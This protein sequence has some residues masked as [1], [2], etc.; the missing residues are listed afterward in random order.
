VQNQD[1]PE[2]TNYALSDMQR[3]HRDF[4]LATW[5]DDG[6]DLTP[7]CYLRMSEFFPHALI[8][9]AGAV[10]PLRYDPIP[11]IAAVTA[12]TRDGVFTLG[13]FVASAPIDG[14]IVMH[15]GRIVYESYPRM[16]ADDHHI[17]WSVTKTLA[18][19]LV[20]KL[21]DD[22]IVDTEQP[23]DAY[24]PELRSSGWE[25]VSVLDILDMA[26]GINCLE[27]DDPVA[28]TS[29]TAPFFQ[30]EA[31]L[32]MLPATRRTPL[33]T[34]DYIAGLKRLQA[35]G[36]VFQYT[37]ANTF[38]LGW[39]AERLRQR[40]FA[41]LVHEELWRHIGAEADAMVVLSTAGAAASHGGVSSTLRDLARYGLLYTPSWATVS[42][43]PII[44]PAYI[45]RI[46]SGGRPEIFARGAGNETWIDVLGEQPR[47]NTSMW[48]L[49]MADGDFFKAGFNGQGLWVS[50]AR[51]LV[52]AFFGH[53]A[54]ANG[55]VRFAR[56]IA[57]SG[58][59]S[60]TET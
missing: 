26:S 45:Q 9:K 28:Y 36:Q 52:I 16:G 29:A 19:A 14:L 44:S 31:T 54:G 24:L 3:A 47:H 40:P 42:R 37:S 30:Y 48:D 11:E 22:G 21:V 34:Y 12:R 38:V 10:S 18:S 56:A 59:F 8:R 60:R 25:G 33:S 32:G 58:L 57:V 15:Q 53:G 2:L 17:W 27:S 7:Y 23:I 13:A 46:Q 4:D 49:V 50:P 35:P 1:A 6:G 20:A 5:Q 41:A 55:A 39:L 43:Q 51:D